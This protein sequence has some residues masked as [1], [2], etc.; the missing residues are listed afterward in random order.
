MQLKRNSGVPQTAGVS[1]E[2]NRIDS[3]MSKWEV[4]D[5]ESTSK[6]KLMLRKLWKE[7]DDTKPFPGSVEEDFVIGVENHFLE[8]RKNRM[9]SKW[10]IIKVLRD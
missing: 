9:E 1:P 4:I 8:P 7:T 10:S 2:R 5:L 6:N 3:L